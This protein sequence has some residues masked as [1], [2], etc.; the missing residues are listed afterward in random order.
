MTQNVLQINYILSFEEITL[1]FITVSEQV[2]TLVSVFSLLF[3]HFFFF[4]ILFEGIFEN[5]IKSFGS[6]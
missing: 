1:K 2:S 3:L 5:Q 6:R 4:K